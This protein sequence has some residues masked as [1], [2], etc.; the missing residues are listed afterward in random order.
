MILK[1]T[2]NTVSSLFLYLGALIG[3]L[4]GILEVF[5]L[6]MIIT[7]KFYDRYETQKCR[8]IKANSILKEKKKLNHCLTKQRDH[9]IFKGGIID[10]TIESDPDL[11]KKIKVFPETINYRED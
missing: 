1:T 7:E 4:V 10:F 11:N 5:G 9:I 2:R 6:V 3:S 8:R